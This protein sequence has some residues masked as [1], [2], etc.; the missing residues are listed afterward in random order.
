MT[1]TRRDR[2]RFP[3]LAVPFHHRAN[4]RAVNYAHGS[5]EL[6]PEP[7]FVITRDILYA[8][9]R[10]LASH[11]CSNSQHMLAAIVGK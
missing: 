6:L 1:T 7:D 4:C 9:D 10:L 5:L 11:Y 8:D 2:P 3:S